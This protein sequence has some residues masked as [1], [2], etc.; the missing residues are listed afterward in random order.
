VAP[1][2]QVGEILL[3]LPVGFT[4]L[5]ERPEDFTLV[6]EDMPIDLSSGWLDYMQRDRLRISLHLNQSSWLTLKGGEYT[7]RFSVL[8]P[9]PLPV[10]NVWQVSL[11]R[12]YYGGCNSVTDP[13][14]LVRFAYPGFEF[15]QVSHLAGAGVLAS[16]TFCSKHV[17]RALAVVALVMA[18]FLLAS[19]LRDFVCVG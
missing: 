8:V 17:D 13:A 12:P 1:L 2:Q 9:S 18:R 10:F 4:H 6:N 5:V 3:S 15:G 19:H 16:G 11:C 7:F 14:V